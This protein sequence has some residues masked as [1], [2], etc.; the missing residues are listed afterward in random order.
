MSGWPRPG[1]EWF[2]EE[3]T[4]FTPEQYEHLARRGHMATCSVCGI[5][6]SPQSLTGEGARYFALMV[7]TG[8]CAGCRV[9][10]A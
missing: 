10:T 3:A 5:T 1:A 2:Y 4:S 6:V 8:K 7:E 9:V